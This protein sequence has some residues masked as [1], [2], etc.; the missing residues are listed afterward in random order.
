MPHTNNTHKFAIKTAIKC[1]IQTPVQ[2]LHIL[3]SKQHIIIWNYESLLL[4]DLF[5]H[6]N[7]SINS[8]KSAA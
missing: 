5:L 3:H 8:H 2:G 4:N 6:Y 7:I 1:F